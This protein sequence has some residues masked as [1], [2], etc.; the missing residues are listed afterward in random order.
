MY[1]VQ[2]TTGANDGRQL[3]RALLQW[4]MCSPGWTT[5]LTWIEVG[6]ASLAERARFLDELPPKLRPSIEYPFLRLSRVL[7]EKSASITRSLDIGRKTTNTHH[8]N[9]CLCWQ[10]IS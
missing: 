4:F 7:P 1:C 8:G 6:T 2:T 10:R 5:I 3:I 9:E